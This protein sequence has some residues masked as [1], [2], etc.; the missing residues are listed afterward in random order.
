VDLEGSVE[1]GVYG[2]LSAVLQDDSIDRFFLAIGERGKSRKNRTEG[3]GRRTA[4]FSNLTSKQT[5]VS[6]LLLLSSFRGSEP[7]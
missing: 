7:L 6:K 5:S 1:L 2:G 3:G 4:E